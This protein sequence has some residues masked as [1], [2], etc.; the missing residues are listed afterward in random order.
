MSDEDLQKK[1][2]QAGLA[3]GRNPTTPYGIPA[4]GELDSLGF[5]AGL[6]EGRALVRKEHLREHKQDFVQRWAG[7]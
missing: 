7:C 1:S 4:P 5:A 6:V 2:F 3:A